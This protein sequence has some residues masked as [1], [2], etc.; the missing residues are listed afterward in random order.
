MT[1]DGRGAM[2]LAD[3]HAYRRL[4]CLFVGCDEAGRPVI[5]FDQSKFYS[6]PD[7]HGCMVSTPLVFPQILASKRKFAL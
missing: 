6:L 5:Y 3:V 7:R 2:S 1:I 4:G